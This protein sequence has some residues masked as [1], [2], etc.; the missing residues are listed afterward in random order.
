MPVT[1]TRRAMQRVATAAATV[2]AWLLL[3]RVN[4]ESTLIDTLLNSVSVAGLA[5]LLGWCVP[6]TFVVKS[7]VR[8]QAVGFGW[9]NLEWATTEVSI[10]IAFRCCVSASPCRSAVHT[11]PF[12]LS[13]CCPQYLRFISRSRGVRRLQQT[14]PLI[15]L[16]LVAILYVERQRSLRHAARLRRAI[17]AAS[18]LRQGPRSPLLSSAVTAPDAAFGAPAAVR[19]APVSAAEAHSSASPTAEATSS[20]VLTA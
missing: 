9:V 2:R 7:Q 13:A 4:I 17:A 10:Y 18:A 12:G 3:H 1:F 5:F 15:A 8:G 20:Q 14:I 19:E 11:C 6:S 16:L